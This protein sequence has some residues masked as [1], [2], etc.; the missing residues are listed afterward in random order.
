MRRRGK[1][2]TRTSTCNRK[3]HEYNAETKTEILRDFN[4]NE[5]NAVNR[6][7]I[8][9]TV[10][11]KTARMSVDVV[12]GDVEKIEITIEMIQNRGEFKKRIDNFK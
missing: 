2:T 7:D 10:G 6:K 12:K 4:K 5:Q 3:D 11:M 8:E 1:R 9:F